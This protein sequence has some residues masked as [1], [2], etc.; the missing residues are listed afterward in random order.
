MPIRKRKIS[1]K[2]NLEKE[3]EN[4]KPG[5]RKQA[6]KEFGEALKNGILRA[7]RKQKSPVSGQNKYK[8]LSK[9][10]KKFKTKQGKA[11]VPNL[12]LEKEM[13]PSIRIDATKNGVELKITDRV[14][15]LKAFNHNTGDTVPKRKFIPDDS[16]D[17]KFKRNVLSDAKKSLKK[18][19][20]PKK[21]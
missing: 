2:L 10:Y 21:G 19:I 4:V 20:K 9:D 1:Y 17:E 3:L 18:Y 7:T 15:K 13:L 5:K 14:E 8:K 16:K 6:A 11:P 12:R